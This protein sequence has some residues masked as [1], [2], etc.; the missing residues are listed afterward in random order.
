MAKFTPVYGSTSIIDVD[1]DSAN[2]DISEIAKDA[3]H[4]LITLMDS[5]PVAVRLGPSAQTATIADMPIT[6]I[7]P[8]LLR[9]NP[10][11][12]NIAAITIAE[13]TSSTIMITAGFAD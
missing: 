7:E 8:V 4:L 6:T 1:M 3:T 9:R 2:V 11:D 5:T 12:D 13:Y 10:N